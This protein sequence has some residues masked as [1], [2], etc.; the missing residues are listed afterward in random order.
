MV[1]KASV[2]PIIKR[3]KNKILLFKENE[4]IKHDKQL[5]NKTTE[6]TLLG[7]KF[8]KNKLTKTLE[9]DKPKYTKEPIKACS[10]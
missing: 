2:T 3:I 10:E 4:K 9:K 1:T 6:H 5:S 8:E 7:L